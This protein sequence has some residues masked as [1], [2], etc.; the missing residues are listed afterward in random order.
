MARS[1]SEIDPL[2]AHLRAHLDDAESWLVYADHLLD[3]GD[4]RGEIIGIEH[5]ISA[6]PA[7]ESSARAQLYQRRAVLETQHRAQWLAGLK[8]PASAEAEWRYGFITG[9]SLRRPLEKLDFLTAL[10][11]HPTGRFLQTLTGFEIGLGDKHMEAL[12][13]LPPSVQLRALHFEGNTIGAAG[14][15]AL[16][17][18]PVC[19]HLET[20]SLDSNDIGDVGVSYITSAASLAGLETLSLASNIL[21]DDSAAALSSSGTLRSLR[22]L[23]LSDNEITDIGIACIAASPA[24]ATLAWLDL[25]GIQ[26]GVEGV[27]ALLQ[28]QTLA[29]YELSLRGCLDGPSL[30]ALAR[31]PFLL[32][33]A[34]IDARYNIPFG[35]EA[36]QREVKQLSV[37][38]GGR[39]HLF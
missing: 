20:L 32:A 24:L 28:S 21:T 2:E 7:S 19:R 12:A 34:H 27:R 6:L 5:R 17:R 9:V 3:C 16:I 11:E 38:S 18:A 36:L 37:A 4:A 22:R 8:L 10:A 29:L 26:I 13:R 39:L 25:S 1:A 33:P 31:G 35:G 30:L 15:R 23:D 14:I